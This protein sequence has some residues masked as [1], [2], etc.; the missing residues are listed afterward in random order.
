[1]SE[2]SNI[3]PGGGLT[4]SSV[5][6]AAYTGKRHDH[7]IRDVRKMLEEL[8]E[9][10]APKF[11]GS[12]LGADGT[13]RPCFHLPKRET[14]I[15]VTGYNVN[16]RAAIIDRWAQLEAVIAQ[17]NQNGGVISGM[18]Q[19]VRAAIGGIVKGQLANLIPQIVE[20]MVVS[21]LAEH[22]LIIRSGKTAKQIW[23]SAGLQP[24]I[25]GSAHWFGNRLKELG[26]MV[27]KGD[28][29]DGTIRLFDPDKADICLRNG[30]R[31]MARRY[32]DERKGQGRFKLVVS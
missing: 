20:P 15:L 7:V 11:G 4:M 1:M 21:R 29:G 25:K 27:G 26:C 2:L 3:I 6:I 19:S 10:T 31:D 13:T 30:L 23:D 16:M 32:A 28:R 22:N 12:Y 17:A 24:R 9:G 14:L 8:G 18:D 5:E